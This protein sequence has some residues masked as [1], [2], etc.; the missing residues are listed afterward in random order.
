MSL[1]SSC[2]FFRVSI[3]LYDPSRIKYTQNI[4]T[5]AATITAAVDTND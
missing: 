2:L 1:I 3:S 5:A 4:E